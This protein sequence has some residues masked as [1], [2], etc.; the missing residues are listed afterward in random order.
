MIRSCTN[1]GKDGYLKP[2]RASQETFFCSLQCKA[3]WSTLEKR[4]L[5]SYEVDEVTGCWNWTGSLRGG[6]GAIKDK[7]MGYGAHRISYALHKGPITDGLLVCHT[8][9]N[10][11]CI[12][13]DHL[14]LGTQKDNMQDCSKKGRIVTHEGERFKDGH[15][16]YNAVLSEEKVLEIRDMIKTGIRASEI[17][18]IVGTS[19]HKINDIIRGKSYKHIHQTNRSQPSTTTAKE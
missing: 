11:K 17:A 10:R 7:K 19:R 18:Q 6:Y 4:L 16:P 13:P 15:V 1:C 8:C 2:A 14:W 3:D 9:D 5:S 12:N